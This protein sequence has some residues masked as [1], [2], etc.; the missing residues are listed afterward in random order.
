MKILAFLMAACAALYGFSPMPVVNLAQVTEAHKQ[1]M[2]E[3]NLILKCEA[4]TTLP[5]T[6]SIDGDYFQVEKGYSFIQIVRDCYV[7]FDQGQFLFS[8]NMSD[9][10]SFDAFFT[11][12]LSISTHTERGTPEISAQA[13]LNKRV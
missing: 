10:R 8:E 1:A 5:F 7:K 11:G 9:W 13:I 4:G 3:N 6:F 12:N 2:I